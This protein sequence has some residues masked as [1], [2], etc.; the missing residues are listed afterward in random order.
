VKGGSRS[1][2]GRADVMDDPRLTVLFDDE[3]GFCAWSATALWRLDRGRALRLVPIR[4]A[5]THVPGSPPAATLLAS[6]HVRDGAGW[7]HGGDAWLRVA[8]A[9]PAL[10]PLHLVGRLPLGRAGVNAAYRVVA[11]N[12]HR[13][14]R[15]LRLDRCTYRGG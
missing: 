15:I 4:E 3:C 5:S 10:R 1:A 13:L 7:T 8:A 12:R 14:S 2:L 6:M 9:V 11:R